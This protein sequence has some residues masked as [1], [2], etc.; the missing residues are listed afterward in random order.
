[1]YPHSF[2]FKRKRNTNRQFKSFGPVK[3]RMSDNKDFEE[4]C[5]ISRFILD[6]TNK[7]ESKLI[8]STCS[9]QSL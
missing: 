5:N 1:M 2:T 7:Y 6:I 8:C 3:Q 9:T 4:V